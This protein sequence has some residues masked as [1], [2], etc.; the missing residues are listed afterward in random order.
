MP[1][2]SIFTPRVLGVVKAVGIL[3]ALAA[4]CVWL[5]RERAS[6]LL[7]WPLFAGLGLSWLS[8]VAYALR[9]R[10]VMAA[11]GFTVGFVPS[12]R[13][14]TLS[15][16]VHFFVPMSVGAE[17]TK[18]LRLRALSP[19]RGNL[20]Q[21]GALA[22]DHAVGFLALL[23][24]TL[25]LLAWRDPLGFGRAWPLGLAAG[26]PLGGLLAARVA[27]GSARLGERL[28]A[29]RARL[30]QHKVSLS[31]GLA[32]SVAMHALLASA[33]FVGARDTGI[34]LAWPELLL[35]LTS[36]G[37]LQ[38]LPVNVAGIGAGEVAGTGLYLALGLPMPDA[39]TLVSL[40]YCY[41]LAMAAVGGLWELVGGSAP[42]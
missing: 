23:A 4:L 30:G 15:V 32:W 16:F 8:M 5:G 18:F 19:G 17:M 27:R 25:G 24:M 10:A 9:F 39:L 35:V 22:L 11:A 21:A 40:L 38:L 1:L 2:L 33:V 28:Q 41:R 12:L 34:A 13:L 29:L 36:A 3:A 6:A 26:L 7:G 37:M 31:Q 20:A 42:R 14:L